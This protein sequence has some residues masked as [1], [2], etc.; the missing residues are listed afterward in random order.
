MESLLCY[1]ASAQAGRIVSLHHLPL[2]PDM[3]D[4]SA[5][6]MRVLHTDDVDKE[7]KFRTPRISFLRQ[8]RMDC[9]YR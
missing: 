1:Y 5:D 9:F 2:I 8:S 3:F 7:G 6:L 4:G